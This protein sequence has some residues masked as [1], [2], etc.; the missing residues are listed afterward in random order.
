MNFF[1][2]DFYLCNSEHKNCKFY[3]FFFTHKEFI[4]VFQ[5]IFKVMHLHLLGTNRRHKSSCNCDIYHLIY[6][7]CMQSVMQILS[8][9]NV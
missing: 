4:C 3:T 6:S 8:F 2:T 5:K 7:L 9:S 1:S